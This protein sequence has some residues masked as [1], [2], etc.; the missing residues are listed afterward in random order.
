M[1]QEAEEYLKYLEDKYR[2]LSHYNSFTVDALKI[3][4]NLGI[5]TIISCNN[6]Y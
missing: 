4:D 5:N 3:D 1:A 2:I 6:D